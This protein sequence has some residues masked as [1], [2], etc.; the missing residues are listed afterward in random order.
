MDEGLWEEVREVGEEVAEGTDCGMGGGGG[1]PEETFL[2]DDRAFIIQM[3][4]FVGQE[5][6]TVFILVL[7]MTYGIKANVKGYAQHQDNDV[8]G[9]EK[10]YGSGIW[11]HGLNRPSLAPRRGRTGEMGLFIFIANLTE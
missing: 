10:S 2:L 8:E 11:I 9:Q 1:A 4:S 7:L 6:V 3:V 5:F